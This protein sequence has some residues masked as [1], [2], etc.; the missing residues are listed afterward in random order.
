MDT[1]FRKIIVGTEEERAL[2]ADLL[3]RKLATLRKKK[4]ALLRGGH[5]DFPE[6]ALLESLSKIREGIR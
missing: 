4:V 5:T 1:P 6:E 3:D 2:F